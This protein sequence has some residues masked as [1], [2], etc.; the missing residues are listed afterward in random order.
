MHWR[1]FALA[2]VMASAGCASAPTER[3]RSAADRTI[4]ARPAID[5]E[6]PGRASN[7][8]LAQGCASLA[9]AG[10]TK[11]P[12]PRA[13]RERARSTLASSEAE[14]ALPPAELGFEVWD[15]PIGAPDRADREGMY[16]VRLGQSF[17][18][19]GARDARARAMAR[20][21]ASMAGEA[22]EAELGAWAQIANTCV[23][24]SL[25]AWVEDVLG[26]HRALLEE[27]RDAAV[28]QLRGGGT[29]D[30]VA[31]ADAELASFERLEHEALSNR[32]A[33]RAELVALI[34]D[35]AEVP[36]DPPPWVEPPP[37]SG[38]DPKKLAETAVA[39]RGVVLASAERT[40]AARARREASE[41][42]DTEPV[43]GVEG[44]YMQTPGA[45]P[46]VGVALTTTLPWIWGGGGARVRAA[47]MSERAARSDEDETKVVVR[48][49]LSRALSRIRTA[50]RSLKDIR[51]RVLPANERAVQAL[52]GTVSTGAFDLKAWLDAGHM[53]LDAH[54]DEARTK[55]ALA[56]AWVD[57]VAS[58]G[59]QVPIEAPKGG[60]Q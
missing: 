43:V 5:V 21:A 44:T 51:E 18:P 26:R 50:E 56:H 41:A 36:A 30:N 58:V 38:L 10:A 60:A 20:E 29:L 32:E 16:M 25:A 27:G 35:A 34:G 55:G 57:L 48:V 23:E 14:A 42:D 45:R 39:R 3:A 6:R 11:R 17:T 46:G 49:E 31:R 40:Q 53:L 12:G 54:L 24:W 28:A 37:S 4:A 1:S 52:H 7:T 2:L 13:I 9:A 33:Q 19:L 15:F 59:G 22:S 47:S 8:A